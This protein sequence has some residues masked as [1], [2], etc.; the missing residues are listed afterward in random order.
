MV[1]ASAS[2]W[3][4]VRVGGLL[5]AVDPTPQTFDNPFDHTSPDL[6]VFGV[7][8]SNKLYLLLGGVWGLVVLFLAVKLLAAIAKFVSAKKV[9]NNP[10]Y[11]SEASSDLKLVAIGF[12]VTVMA[13][14]IVAGLIGI[15]NN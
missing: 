10:D 14:P 12:V 4:A 11:L 2:A 1:G 13:G 15:F 8:L 3:A 6:G 5:P 7:D 9:Q